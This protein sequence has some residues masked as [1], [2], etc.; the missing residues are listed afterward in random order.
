MNRGSAW[1]LVVGGL[2]GGLGCT[3]DERARS[4]DAEAIGDGIADTSAPGDAA[5]DAM[6]DAG[7]D[8]ASDAM[9]EAPCDPA[10]LTLRVD[11]GALCGPDSDMQAIVQIGP[12]A[13]PAGPGDRLAFSV[14]CADDPSETSFSA[15]WVLPLDRPIGEVAVQSALASINRVAP[16]GG[17]HVWNALWSPAEAHRS[18]LDT[19]TVQA[20]GPR[21]FDATL[22]G[23]LL[24]GGGGEAGE[25]RFMVMVRG[26]VPPAP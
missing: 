1:L 9:A 10:V 18:T 21:C 2:L 20:R 11:D 4:D 15:Q 22:G 26:E 16:A 3:D 8:A 12:L 25:R 6:A 17:L 5:P 7:G 14:R 24:P 23:R 19:V 13:P